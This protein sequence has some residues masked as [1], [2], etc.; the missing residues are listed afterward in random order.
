MR[1]L[2]K[3]CVFTFLSLVAACNVPARTGYDRELGEYGP[4]PESTTTSDDF[5]LSSDSLDAPVDSEVSEDLSAWMDVVNSWLG[6][7]YK[8]GGSSK[9]GTDCSGYVMQIYKEKTGKNLP[10]SSGAMFKLGEPIDQEDL[11]TGDLVF[12]GGHWGINHVGVY[13]SNGNFTHSS[14][15][16]GVAIIP[17]STKYWKERYR[18]ARRLL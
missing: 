9:N 11:Q 13:L 18:G 1:S 8:Y 10:H 16:D 7:P 6:T 4:P 2:C 15:S 3:L 17:L 12:F 5:N 14:S